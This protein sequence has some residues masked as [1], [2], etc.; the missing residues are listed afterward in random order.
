[1]RCHAANL[2]IACRASEDQSQQGGRKSNQRAFDRRTSGKPSEIY[3]LSH[4]LYVSLASPRFIMATAPAVVVLFGG[5]E[6]KVMLPIRPSDRSRKSKVVD[7]EDSRDENDAPLSFACCATCSH[8]PPTNSLRRVCIVSF[9]Y[10]NSLILGVRTPP[11]ERVNL[12]T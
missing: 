11:T 9:P 4:P 1:L 5:M 7:P 8:K 6:R 3:E 2:P 12:V 10:P